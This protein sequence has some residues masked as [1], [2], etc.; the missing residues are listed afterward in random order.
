MSLAPKNDEAEDCCWRPSASLSHLQ[1]RALLLKQ[2]R[3]FF[4]ARQVLEVETPL[5]C[6]NVG[7]DPHLA[8]FNVFS[9]SC[10]LSDT[11]F[12][13]LYLQTSPE[14][15][16][17]RLLSAGSGSIYQI[18]KAFRAE[19]IG[20][21]H[22]PEFTMLEWYRVGWD[23]YVLMD[24]VDDLLALVLGCS[25][26]KRLSY[27]AL[28]KAYLGFDPLGTS[29]EILRRCVQSY[30]WSLGLQVSD[31]D[32]DACSNLLMSHCIEPY[33]GFESPLMVDDYPSSKA[34][35]AKLRQRSD[36]QWVSERFEVYI[37]GMELANGYHELSDPGVY[38]QRALLDQEQ[39]KTLGLRSI[40]IDP[41]FLAALQSGLPDSAGIALGVDRL[42]MLKLGL[43]QIAQVMSFDQSRI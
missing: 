5:L 7:T 4:E 17:K 11:D 24:E 23:H 8:P 34:A 15:A 21:L 25:K 29:V 14:F 37:Q 13:K 30:E 19:D 9:S 27:S 43:R 41:Y 1:A 39:R 31:L 42:L 10:N 22:N 20:R 33:L 36:G 6:K 40:A 18:S 16:M 26:A 35:L 38:E 28:F 32:W 12:D 3:C 2:I